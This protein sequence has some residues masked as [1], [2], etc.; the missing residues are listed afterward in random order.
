MHATMMRVHDP[1]KAKAFF[2]DKMAF[3]TG[4]VELERMLK[5]GQNGI[6]VVDVREAEDYA[7]GHIPGAKNLPRDKWNTFEG[8]QRDKTNVVYCYT[9]VCHLG[10]AAC[11]EFAG[12][13]FPVMELE[14]GFEVW[15]ENGLDIEPATANRVKSGAR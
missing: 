6:N 13:G 14:G 2:E 10:A 1:A 15:K 4:P 9:H 3:T 7:K 5:S 8:L 12:H 11:V